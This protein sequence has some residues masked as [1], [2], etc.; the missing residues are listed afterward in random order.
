[1]NPFPVVTLRDYFAA[2]CPAEE[3]E[4]RMPNTV[5]EVAELL[6]SRGIIK[7]W[8]DIINAYSSEDI[9]KLRIALRYEY[10]DAM[11][12]TR[13]EQQY[14][15]RPPAPPHGSVRRESSAPAHHDER[16]ADQTVFELQAAFEAYLQK[17]SVS[18][19]KTKDAWGREI[20][21]HSHVQAEWTG[22]LFGYSF[23]TGIPLKE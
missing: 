7:A 5:G 16:S 15:Q 14:A 2:H 3:I 1:M 17:H 10:A 23:A 8:T 21:Y 11:I 18:A 12:K 9:W 4:D 22:V 13:N 19:E 20:Y 6:K